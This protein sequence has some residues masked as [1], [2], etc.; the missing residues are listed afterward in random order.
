MAIIYIRRFD[1]STVK[2]VYRVKNFDQFGIRFVSPIS[3]M[4]LPEED[5]DANIL[6][7]M[8]GNTSTM[9]VSWLI[10]NEQV[11]IGSAHNSA[12]APGETK[13]IFQQ[14]K[15]WQDFMIGSSITTSFDIAVGDGTEGSL[16]DAFPNPGFLYQKR[17]FVT[18]VD[19][20]TNGAEPNTFRA[21]VT[22]MIGDVISSYNTDTPSEP[23]NFQGSPGGSS[24]EIDLT[25]DDPSDDGGTTVSKH[26]V[27]YKTGTGTWLRVQP[28][29]AANAV[30]LT[31]L[32]GG[33]E[34]VIKM[35]AE[36]ANGQGRFTP[37]RK[38]IA[39]V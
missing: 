7:K 11:N 19:I 21:T 1:D 2:Y 33:L 3:P 39:T 14:L 13:D 20:N 34:Y 23:L 15:F 27:L 18:N 28:S 22:I 4:P 31:G 10:R 9:T 6:V 25:W 30:T 17:G 26:N 29:A 36:N 32:T 38:V 35:N 24:Q 16:D 5:D 37:E 8:E 12:P